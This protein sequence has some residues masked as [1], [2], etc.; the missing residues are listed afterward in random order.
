MRLFKNIP[1]WGIRGGFILAKITPIDV[2]KGISGKFGGN[3]NEYFS[4]NKS[5]NRIHLSKLMNP[6]KGPATERQEEIREQFK[7]RAVAATKW[8]ND[9]KPSETNGVKGTEAYQL[10]QSLKKLQGLSNVRQVVYKH[11]D[12]EGKVTF[13]SLTSEP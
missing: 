2:I 8:L 10:A 3:A 4:T 6:Y 1:L 11:M 12:D 13:P 9:N 7:I 5:S